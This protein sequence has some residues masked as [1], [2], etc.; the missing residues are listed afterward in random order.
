MIGVS[1]HCVRL[2]A[3][4]WQVGYR[5]DWFASHWWIDLGRWRLC[6]IAHLNI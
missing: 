6:A 2:G 1:L 5:R 3:R 4:A